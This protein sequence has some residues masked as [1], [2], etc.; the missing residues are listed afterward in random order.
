ME[1]IKELRD[2][3]GLTILMIE[4]QMAVIMGV[5]ERILGWIMV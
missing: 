2:N 4:H 5:C 1:F 3:F